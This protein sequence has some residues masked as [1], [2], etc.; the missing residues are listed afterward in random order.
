MEIQLSPGTYHLFISV[1]YL[2]TKYDVNFTYYG[3]TQVDIKRLR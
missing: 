2:D 1:D 3:S